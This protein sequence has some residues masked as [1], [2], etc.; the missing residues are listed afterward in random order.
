MI[1]IFF[2]LYVFNPFPDPST[3]PFQP[4]FFL[5]GMYSFCASFYQVTYF[6][7]IVGKS[8]PFSIIFQSLKL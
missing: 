5:E 3:Y 7:Y 1:L 2:S 4:F 6:R 8:T